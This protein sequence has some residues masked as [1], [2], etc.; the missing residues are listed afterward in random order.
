VTTSPPST[1]TL[2][3]DRAL[4][5]DPGIR[6]I[7]REIYQSV[8]ALPIVSMHGHVPVEWFADDTPFPD[9]AQLL[10]VPDHYLLRMIVSQGSYRLHDLGVA[11]LDG[12][13][14]LESDPR[15]IWRRFCESWKAF[16]GTPTRFWMETEL[17]EIFGVTQ[18]PS[19]ATA[20]A[21]Y[22]Q[23]A[24]AIAAPD[25]RPRAL[26]DRFGIEVIATTDPAWASLEHH[27]KLAADG[28]GDRVLPTFRPDPLLSLDN[29]TFTHDVLATGA[30]AGIAVHDYATYLDALRAQRLRFRA[31]GGRATDHG[32]YLPDT[33]PLPDDDAARL[34]DTAFTG[35]PVTP[36]QVAAFSA[37]MLFQMAQMS[38]DDGLV[39][40]IHPGVER[41][42]DRA[43]TAVYGPDK[44]YDIPVA[45]EYTRALRPMLEAFGNHPGFR[46]IVFTID[47]DVY[48][49]EL[50]PLAGVYPAMRV[51]APWWFIDS[52]EGMRRF[53]ETVTETAGFSNTS[54]FVDDTRAFC[55]IPARHDLARRIDAGYLARL[56]AE[57]RLD[58]DEAVD[59]AAD[60][61]YH[62]PL[63]AYAKA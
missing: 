46:T 33:T 19:A 14:A 7:A 21:I 41:G 32:P 38:C 55:S 30:A 15:A 49:R 56:V 18:R 47:E 17:V 23:V 8:K 45:V 34:F 42:H 26:L 6:P 48:T 1:W 44:G 24:A 53:R 60:L 29:P 61:A 37:H 62:L 36:A 20:D 39:M 12:S 25:F 27:A 63:L 4:P 13:A 54:G 5:A 43:A 52:P 58:L 11:T 10:V 50:A 2:H 35:K 22:D 40:Q 3:E 57:H 9:P 51:G 59:T 28:L 16:R 31:A